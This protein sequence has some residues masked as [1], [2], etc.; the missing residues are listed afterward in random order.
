MKKALISKKSLFPVLAIILVLAIAVTGA[1]FAMAQGAYTPSDLSRRAEGSEPQVFGP[2]APSESGGEIA[3][4]GEGGPASADQAGLDGSSVPEAAPPEI[5]D[6]ISDAEL[7]DLQAIASQKGISLQAAIDRYAWNDNFALA[8]AKIREASP[9]TFAR[10]EIVDAGHAWVG[11]AGPAPEAAREMIDAFG[12]NHS[13]VSVSVRIDL[14]F[15]E[16]E[17]ERA[18]EAVHFAVLETPEVCDAST[19]FDFATGQITTSIVL[20]G[21][22]SDSVLDDLEAIAAKNLTDATR[23]DILNSITVSVVR[24]NH[25]VTGGVESNAEHLGG[26]TLSTC[27][28]GFV[29]KNS[30][31][32]RG[33]STAGHCNDSQTDDGSSL[34]YKEEYVGTHGDFQWHTGPQNEPDDFYSGNDSSTE[35]NRRDVSSVGTPVVGQSLCR[36]GRTSYKGCQE[37]RKLNVCNGDACNLVEMGEHLSADGDSGGPVFWGNTAYGL[38]QGWIYDP[39]WPFDRQ[40]FSRA[41]RIDDALGI[42]IATN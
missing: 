37:V 21:T 29:T 15:T 31:G 17:L 26:E 20:E 14:G 10:A 18:I 32:V 7:Q 1:S 34:T 13:G 19:S 42:S 27:T 39:I 5:D 25:N 4:S 40:V 30:S 33:I 6:P 24:S 12:N 38:H 9:A 2:T 16:V 41:D 35:V 23:P 36:N 22:A 3:A 11:F 28:S 8:V